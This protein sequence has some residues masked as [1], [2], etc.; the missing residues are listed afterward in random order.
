MFY[1]FIKSIYNISGKTNHNSDIFIDMLKLNEKF[2]YLLKNKEI[3]MQYGGSHDE[4]IK[5]LEESSNNILTN[6]KIVEANDE[7][8]RNYIL[9]IQKT[10]DLMIDYTKVLY[11]N[12]PTDTNIKELNRQLIEINGILNKY[13]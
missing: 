1:K 8:M 6:L 4:D 5:T 13:I 2:I 7:N 3:N 11:T 9:K 10:L 12:S